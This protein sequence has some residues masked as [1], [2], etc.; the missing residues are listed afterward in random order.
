M[1]IYA[2]GMTV[3]VAV[4][5]RLLNRPGGLR[6]LETRALEAATSGRWVPLIGQSFPLAK[7]AEAH[8]AVE[9]RATTGKTVL[10][11]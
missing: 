3:G 4:G 10:K 6:E 5:P 8:A 2:H 11:P 1:D 9:N 7:A